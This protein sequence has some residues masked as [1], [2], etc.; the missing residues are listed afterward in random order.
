[1]LGNMAVNCWIFAIFVKRRSKL[2]FHL[3]WIK[4]AYLKDGLRKYFMTECA[5][6]KAVKRLILCF[7]NSE[8][9]W[10]VINDLTY[11]DLD[12]YYHVRFLS[13]IFAFM[14]DLTP[15]SDQLLLDRKQVH[16]SFRAC[17]KLK[18][19]LIN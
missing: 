18:R 4:I 19:N 16:T 12:K 10:S 13:I 14:L 11:Q 5:H 6:L 8:I 3:L 2:A 9:V 7:W 1:M 17:I 15:S